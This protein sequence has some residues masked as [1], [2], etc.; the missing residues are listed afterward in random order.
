MRN[1]FIIIAALLLISLSAVA[2]SQNW[3][4]MLEDYRQLSFGSVELNY[5]KDTPAIYETLAIELEK[6][7][8]LNSEEHREW[9]EEYSEE[10]LAEMISKLITQMATALRLEIPETIIYLY[11]SREEL[12]RVTS[13]T[14]SFYVSM[15]NEVH[16]VGEDLPKILEFVLAFNYPN[17]ERKLLEGIAKYYL[18]EF[19]GVHQKAQ[20]WLNF[21]ELPPLRS[22]GFKSSTALDEKE[23][24]AWVSFLGYILEEYNYLDWGRVINLEDIATN[25]DISLTKLESEWFNYLQRTFCLKLA[26]SEEVTIG[27]EALGVILVENPDKAIYNVALEVY[28]SYPGI[29]SLNLIKTSSYMV[30][31]TYERDL[32]RFKVKVPD[33]G[34]KEFWIIG[35][36]TYRDTSFNK[37]S[38]LISLPVTITE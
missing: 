17:M 20:Y 34:I 21:Q 36:L 1:T 7:L 24:D 37:Q 4:D 35:K 29:E 28:V 19:N 23:W 6:R 13:Y 2:I 30:I 16:L 27:E 10:T 5:H 3:L 31:N 14:D 26:R 11:P 38:S 12:L 8:I 32:V 18:P 33:L 9:I 15:G 25:L 22:F